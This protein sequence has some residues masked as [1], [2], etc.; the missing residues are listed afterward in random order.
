[1][2]QRER[3]KIAQELHDGIA[4]DL[5][6]LSYSLD[7][8]LAAPDTPSVTRIELRTILFKVS[9]LI[10]SVRSE[11]FN[12]RAQELI[13]F[14]YSLRS[15]LLEL[16]SDV[17]LKIVRDDCVLSSH[18][19]EELLAISRELLRNSIKHSGASVIEISIEKSDTGINYTYRDNGKGM[20]E[21]QRKGFG[22]LGIQERCASI[23]GTLTM[24]STSLGIDYF[25]AIPS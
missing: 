13:S 6:G 18:I 19:E 8:L 21:N 3:I 2:T 17:E 16:K 14:E 5:V 20:N 23:D 10:E 9:T 12:L 11:I 24:S 1:M 15:L 4:Q 25:I 22:I 7:L